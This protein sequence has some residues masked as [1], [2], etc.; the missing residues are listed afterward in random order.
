MIVSDLCLCYLRLLLETPRHT[1]E[2]DTT[3]TLKEI[4]C[5]DMDWINLS[6]DKDKWWDI[7]KTELKVWLQ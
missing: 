7:V 4:G 1:W 2:D 3:M 5:E 6:Q